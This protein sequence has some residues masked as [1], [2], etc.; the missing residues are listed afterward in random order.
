MSNPKQKIPA[1]SDFLSNNKEKI[2]NK[3]DR[4]AIDIHAMPK[5]SESSLRVWFIIGTTTFVII[6]FLF[7]I[8]N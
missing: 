8:F 5:T 7:L 6:I 1:S 3:Q 2:S 4:L